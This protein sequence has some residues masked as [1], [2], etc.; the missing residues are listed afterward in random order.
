MGCRAQQIRCWVEGKTCSH[1]GSMRASGHFSRHRVRIHDRVRNRNGRVRADLANS[2]L[3]RQDMSK[4]I[5][6]ARHGALVS[7]PPLR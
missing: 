7:E 5:G 2:K 4:S 3:L 6:N 1:R